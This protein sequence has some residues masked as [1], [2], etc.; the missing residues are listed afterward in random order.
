M[1]LLVHR[2]IVFKIY[3][4]L[5]FLNHLKFHLL[6]GVPHPKKKASRTVNMCKMCKNNSTVAM[7]RR[8]FGNHLISIGHWSPRSSDLSPCDYFL[9]G[10]VKDHVFLN[11][12]KLMVELKTNITEVTG[13]VNQKTLKTVFQ[14]KLRRIE[15][16]L[17][18]DGGQ[19][20]NLI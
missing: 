11:V 15:A 12:P 13:N 14:N 3:F 18:A 9:W 17:Q 5:F 4:I 8:C 19:F 20:E 6:Q 7:L 10:Y 1:L 2:N 16:C